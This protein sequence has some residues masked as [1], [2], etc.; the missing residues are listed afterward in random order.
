[1]RVFWH[2]LQLSL[3]RDLDFR[4][5]FVLQ[6]LSSL[7]E[8][9][10]VFGFFGLIYRAQE[11]IGWWTWDRMLWLIAVNHVLVCLS[12]FLFGSL[13]QL[14]THVERGTL[15][16]VLVRPVSSRLILSVTRPRWSRLVAALAAVPLVL[17]SQLNYPA[18]HTLANWVWFGLFMLAGLFIRYQLLF[19]TAVAAFWLVR[20]DA[21]IFVGDS[22]LSLARYPIDV[23]PQAARFLLTYILPIVF[24][25]NLPVLALYG[26]AA[27]GGDVTCWSQA[28]LKCG[29]IDRVLASG[30]S[31]RG[32][33]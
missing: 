29:G 21:L 22:A 17:H 4:G 19:V 12:D 9:A 15:D 25:S 28:L 10:V 3:K 31:L 32:G 18:V 23:F 33:R 27:S 30:V 2:S 1:M 24:I 6:V 5:N 11:A 7:L 26:R 20:V 16:Y 13:R 8:L 14:G